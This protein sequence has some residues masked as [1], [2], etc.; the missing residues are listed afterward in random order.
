LS[1]RDLYTHLWHQ[2]LR[3]EVPDV[4]PD[5]SLCH[6]DILGGWSEED[7]KLFFRY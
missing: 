4:E 7:T 5:E 3:E 2:T 1:D 6:V